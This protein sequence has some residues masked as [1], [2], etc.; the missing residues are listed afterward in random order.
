ML[1]G[2]CAH[3]CIWGRHNSL[4]GFREQSA[5]SLGSGVRSSGSVNPESS[6][7]TFPLPQVPCKENGDDVKVR[8]T[9][10]WW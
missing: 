6:D 9:S 4:H 10:E 8:P 3:H 7:L 2:Q 1:K 5:E